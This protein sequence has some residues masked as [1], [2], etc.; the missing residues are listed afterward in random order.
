MHTYTHPQRLMFFVFSCLQ[1]LGHTQ[2]RASKTSPCMETLH[3][4]NEDGKEYVCRACFATYLPV[5]LLSLTPLSILSVFPLPPPLLALQCHSF[6]SSLPLPVLIYSLFNP[7]SSHPRI[8]FPADWDF[9]FPD[10]NQDDLG[11]LV[12][13]IN[14]LID[15]KRDK[16]N[17]RSRICRSYF[18]RL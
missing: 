11:G 8:L 4:H 9:F 3:V 17:K 10:Q 14:K 18:R 5:P 13:I 1:I 15:R 12:P 7:T 6:L 2:P 16:K